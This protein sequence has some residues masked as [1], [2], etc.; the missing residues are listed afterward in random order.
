[1][2]REEKS[3]Q[4]AQWPQR[5]LKQ[6]GTEGSCLL[7]GWPA[8][9]IGHLLASEPG[10]FAMSRANLDAPISFQAGIFPGL[11]TQGGAWHRGRVWLWVTFSISRGSHL[12]VPL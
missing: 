12:W 6:A 9:S 5:R 1:M 2:V 10:G 3:Q 4:F 11:V 8:G 7:S